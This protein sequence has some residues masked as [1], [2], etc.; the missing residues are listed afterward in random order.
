MIA[1]SMS[2]TPHVHLLPGTPLKAA[3]YFVEKAIGRGGFGI[4]YRALDI[5]TR[6]HVALKELF[7]A[8]GCFRAENGALVLHPDHFIAFD[9]MRSRFEF[10]ARLLSQLRHSAVI[11]LLDSFI[12]NNTVY[13]VMPFIE[14]P[15]L[16]EHLKREGRMLEF[17]ARHMLIPL[18]EALFEVHS[19][20][21]LHCDIKPANILLG[22]GGPVLIDFGLSLPYSP[23]RITEVSR[24][25]LTKGYAP[26]EQYGSRAKLGP[27]TDLYALAS[28][29]FE[30]LTNQPI[31][32]APDRANG[33]ML[34]NIFDLNPSVSKNL[35]TAL[36]RALSLKSEQRPQ[37]AR[38]MLDELLL[39]K[40]R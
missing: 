6:R 14:G 10:E 15:T 36:K 28:T 37:S 1:P 21:A 30:V 3:Q 40:V 16:Y 13:M 25:L 33:L 32:P 22:D 20:G 5:Q 19:N 35:G 26:L 11:R 27:Y 31:P 24:A 17:E 18:L 2:D 29:F 9:T 12:E 4:T 38:E 8:Q 39:W 7:P 23:G 34:P